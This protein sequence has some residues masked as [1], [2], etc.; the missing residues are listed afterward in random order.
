MAKTWFITGDQRRD[1]SC[2][3]SWAQKL[4]GGRRSRSAEIQCVVTL[5]KLLAQNVPAAGLSQVVD[6]EKD[7]RQIYLADDFCL[8]TSLM[9][10]KVGLLSERET[11]R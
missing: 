9:R 4:I 5:F 7:E 2:R 10:R 8:K 1:E 3:F 11:R 6:G